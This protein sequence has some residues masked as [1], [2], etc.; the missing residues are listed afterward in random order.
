[1]HDTII[2]MVWGV[3][4]RKKAKGR[5]DEEAA[6][7]SRKMTNENTEMLACYK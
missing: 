7:K 4:K 3:G 2:Y 5:K 6:E 1:M